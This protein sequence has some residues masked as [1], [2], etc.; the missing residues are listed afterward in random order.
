MKK[1]VAI[2]LVLVMVL[3]LAACSNGT[4][5]KGSDKNDTVSDKKDDSSNNNKGDSGKKDS[6]DEEKKGMIYFCLN[7]GDKG[8]NDNG[9]W[10]TQDAAEKYGLEATLVE[11]GNDTA[12]YESAFVDACESGKYSYVITQ[13][14]YGLAD[15]CIKYGPEYPDIKFIAF[16]AG[17]TADFSSADNAFGVAFGQNEGSW[18]AGVIAGSLT[19]SNKVGVFIF[20]D[21]PV[22]NDFLVGYLEGVRYANPDC[23]IEWAYGTQGGDNAKVKE[24]CGLMY[25]GGCDVVYVVSGGACIAVAEDV[26][27]NRGGYE[28]GNWVIGCDSDQYAMA[29]ENEA[30]AAYADVFITSMLKDVRRAVTYSVDRAMEGTLPFGTVEMYGLS[31]GGVGCVDNEWFRTVAPQEVQDAYDEALEAVSS[32]KV[33]ISTYFEF[34]DYDEYAVYRDSFKS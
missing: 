23:E 17:M 7:L 5:D 14:N 1:L 9:W 15:L 13:S 4:N 20:M 30:K 11:L 21:V 8:F 16:D 10:G 32:G 27:V 2:L 34:A 28:A 31:V 12:T 33:D 24:I 6:D 26:T 18:L 29:K 3:A 19:E 25:D 22:G